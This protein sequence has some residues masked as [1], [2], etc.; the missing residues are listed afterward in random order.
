[1]HTMRVDGR[2]QRDDG[3]LRMQSFAHLLGDAEEAII[4]QMTPP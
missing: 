3:L 2:L 1:M 4:G